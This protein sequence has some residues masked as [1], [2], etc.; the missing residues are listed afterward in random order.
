MIKAVKFASIAVSDQDRSLEFFTTK[1]GFALATDQPFSDTQRW[2]EL[3]I[4]GADTRIVL[5]TPPGHE[6]R[7]GGF[8]NV[9]FVADN[10][11]KTYEELLARGV[12]FTGPPK[13]A[14]WG[15]S[16]MF[17]DPDGNTFLIS[18]K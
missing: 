9:T 2:I 6:N 4:P 12:E 10:V 11:E 7:I 3:R 1:L 13:S 16:A 15:S 8:S 14:Q 5:F 18:S 17:R